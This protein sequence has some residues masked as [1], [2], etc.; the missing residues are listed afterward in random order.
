MKC[1]ILF[2]GKANFFKP[3]LDW[4]LNFASREDLCDISG[5]YTNNELSLLVDS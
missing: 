2:N 5:I 3:Y 4:I 1:G